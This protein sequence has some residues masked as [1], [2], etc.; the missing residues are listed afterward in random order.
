MFP[1][2][3]FD[4]FP[5]IIYSN[6]SVVDITKRVA[7]LDRVSKNPYVFYPFDL[8]GQE[9]ADQLSNRYYEDSYKSW[10]F[11]LSNKIMDPYYEWYLSEA[12]LIEF[13]EKKYGSI[14]DAQEKIKFYRN[15]W[16]NKD[17]ISVS[18]YD[19]LSEDMKKYWNP[20]YSVGSKILNYVR[21]EVDWSTNTNKVI[22]YAVSNSNYIVNEICNIR[23]QGEELGRGQVVWSSNTHLY[24]QHVFGTF[25]TSD[26]VT[27]SSNSY[28]YGIESKANSVITSISAISNNIAEDEI[29]YW[30]PITY[31]EYET[32]KNE[33]NK[34][35]RVMDKDNVYTA[36]D[37]LRV[38]L[39]TD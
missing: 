11:Y 6:N 10:V 38:L 31:Y 25:Y 36:V 22:S 29:I 27:L 39:E 30:K 14:V 7:L 18:A 2:K 26:T 3:Y 23:L 35:I 15:D 20:A 24:L 4:K 19:A 21:K 37:N 12:E 32:E 33:Y 16:E 1:D 5:I 17:P 34:S 9:R 13:V 8:S 28:V